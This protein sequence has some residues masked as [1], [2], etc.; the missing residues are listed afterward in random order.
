ML[1]KQR[2]ARSRRGI[3]LR[4]AILCL[5]R[6]PQ[7]VARCWLVIH[8]QNRFHVFSALLCFASSASGKITSNL[9]PFPPLTGLTHFRLPSASATRRATIANPSPV[10]CD[11]VV[12]NGRSE[13]R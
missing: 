10:P 6:A 7:P 11:F 2:F 1:S 12:K 3:G 13:E 8:N 5:Q 9:V 4:N